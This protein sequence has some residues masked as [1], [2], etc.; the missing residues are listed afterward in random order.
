MAA[1]SPQL[2]AL[3]SKLPGTGWV[4]ELAREQHPD[5]SW[6]RFHSRDSKIRSR[7]PS[8]EEAIRRAIALGLEKDDHILKQAIRYMLGVLVGRSNWSDRVEKS[9]GW[10]TRVEAISAG[11]LAQVDPCHPAVDRASEYWTEIAQRTFKGGRYDQT[12]EIQAHRETRGVRMIYLGSRYVLTLLG[13][14]SS[15]LSGELDRQIVGWIWNSPEGIGYLGADLK[16]P[17]LFHIN[18]WLDSLEILSAFQCWRGF[19]E[20]AMDWLWSIRQEDNLWDFG[21]RLSKTSYF[22][23]SDDWRKVRTRMMDHSTRV[24]ALL[25]KFVE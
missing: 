21:A 17:V 14:R 22:P 20:P 3:K 6:G 1:G 19:A 4:E 18:Q 11:T 15:L 25:R 12:R 23:L 24:L 8:S 13:S 5:G 9:E 2:V 16:K 7:F 10:P